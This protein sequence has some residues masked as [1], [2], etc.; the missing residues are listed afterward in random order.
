MAFSDY[1]PVTK[2]DL[3]DLWN[4][5]ERKL[6]TM[7]SIDEIKVAV[8]KETDD[9]KSAII[10]AVSKETGE[11]VDQVQK[12]KDAGRPPTQEDLDEIL[13]SIRSVAPAVVAA[14]DTISDNDG[15]AAAQPQS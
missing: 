13:T 12:L 8:K 4:K 6:N 7:P 3:S 15:A 10:L 11:V 9:L 1:L 2:R 14:I 5:L